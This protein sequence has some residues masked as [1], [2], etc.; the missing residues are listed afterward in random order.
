MFWCSLVGADR[1][2]KE[3]MPVVIASLEQE[4][5]YCNR[6]ICI[7]VSFAGSGK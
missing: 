1:P 5:W 4:N 2:P 7:L 3:I 6:N